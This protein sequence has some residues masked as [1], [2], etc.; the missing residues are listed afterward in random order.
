MRLSVLTMVLF[1]LTGCQ[2]MMSGCPPLIAYSA[3][4]Q[5]QA[6]SE[7]RVLLPHDS[8]L[9]RMIVDYGKMRDAC[10]ASARIAP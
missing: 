9:G 10:R 1:S 5:K 8:Q 3:A 2:T 7:L 4:E 6:S